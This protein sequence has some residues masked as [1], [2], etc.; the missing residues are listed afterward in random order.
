VADLDVLGVITARGGSKGLP[1]KNVLPVA[2]R[3]LIAWTIAAAAASR[4][5]TRTIVS[6]D[7]GEIARVCRECGADVPFLRPAALASD[8]A[9]HLDVIE[10]ALGWAVVDAGREPDYVLVLQP[11][12]P[13]RTRDDI[14][15]AVAIARE[16]RAD[17]VVSVT[18]AHPHP[19][20]ASTLRP[21]GTLLP[22][23]S[24]EQAS[25]RRQ[26]MPPAYAL[27]GAI[28]LITPAALRRHRTFAPPAAHAYIMPAE[29][30]IDIDS[31][32]DLAIAELLLG[33]HAE[34]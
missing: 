26:D 1:R 10:H 2:G 23:V 17:A 25:A 19:W 5:V 27:N 8:T 33:R 12:S 24:A 32:H 7:D 18:A 34:V 20:L 14:D 30:S 22:L 9:T 16:R 21:D 31:A 29:R 13:L 11:T 4:Q 28:F 15:A 6:T 3:P